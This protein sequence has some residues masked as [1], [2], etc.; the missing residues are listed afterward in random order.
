GTALI[1]AIE[2]RGDFTRI[3]F[4]APE[5]IK[6]YILEKGCVAID[7]ISLT[8]NECLSRGFTIM[9]IPHTLAR[10]TLAGKRTGDQVNIENDILGKYVEKF[11][12]KE[13]TKGVTRELLEKFNFS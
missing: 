7:G 12:L 10:T 5:N 1:A 2:R 11:L 9:I 13:D 3:D 8:V 6:K 4:T